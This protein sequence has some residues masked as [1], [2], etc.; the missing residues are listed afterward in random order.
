[1]LDTKERVMQDLVDEQFLCACKYSHNVDLDIR[2]NIRACEQV[3][4]HLHDK[5]FYCDLDDF[6]RYLKGFKASE[7]IRRFNASMN[8]VSCIIL[9]TAYQEANINFL[10]DLWKERVL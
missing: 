5:L 1:M 8:C 7:Y 9:M 10:V 6:K 4:C 3:F 2:F